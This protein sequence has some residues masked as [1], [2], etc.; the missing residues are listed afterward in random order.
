M[1]NNRLVK[2]D[3]KVLQGD[4]KLSV[5]VGRCGGSSCDAVLNSNNLFEE[6]HRICKLLTSKS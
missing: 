5:Q 3:S 1:K 2:T 4:N 6:K